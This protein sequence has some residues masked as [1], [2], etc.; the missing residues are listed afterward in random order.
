MCFF[1]IVF[2]T[3]RRFTD[4]LCLVGVGLL[5]VAPLALRAHGTHSQLME[6]V[7]RKIED[8]PDDANLWYQRG[9]L[10]LEHEDAVQ[11]LEDLKKAESLAPGKLPTL[12][13]KGLALE[14][15]GKLTDA[16]SALD[17]HILRFPDHGRGYS[18]RARVL[19]KLGRTEEALADYRTALSKT[20]NAE[21]DL[22]QES[23]AAM[24]ANCHE[25]EAIR[26]LDAGVERLGEIPSLMMKALEIEVK[27]AR[28]DL[29]LTRVEAI[30]KSAP[31]PE[32]WMA[33]RAELL[34]Q[35]QQ[36]EESRAAWQA[37]IAHLQNLPNLERGSNSMS[38]LAERAHQAIAILDQPDRRSIPIPPG[39][40][41]E[42]E[43][44]RAN[45]Q[46][47]AAP[48]DGKLW[49]QRS[50]LLLA[51]GEFQQAL[52]DCD[53]A[54]FLAPSA[55]PTG[56]VRG[57]AWAGEGDLEKGKTVLDDFLTT[58]P[59]HVRGHAARARLLL[60]LKQTDSALEDYQT[61]LQLSNGRP[62]IELVLE[63]VG[64]FE[65]NGLREEAMRT[66][67]TQI[68]ILGENP[69]LLTRALETETAAAQY[70]AAI[71]RVDALAKTS[72]QPEVWMA[73]RAGLLSLAGRGAEARAAWSAILHHIDS[74]PNL[75][76]GQPTMVA[77]AR[78]AETEISSTDTLSPSP[79]SFK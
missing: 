44:Q 55:F 39:A 32:P 79:D 72:P 1:P 53:T 70:D 17:A 62:E 78:Q 13:L 66:L 20:P 25:D 48:S 5:C 24:A 71:S 26:I 6:V 14:L 61:A 60:Q 28:Y 37:L 35:A 9:F 15:S 46:I 34:A 8:S 21:P 74:L 2:P 63:A 52:Q 23:A 42:E 75:Q 40:V 65:A 30:E 58:H 36:K 64:A 59:D 3:I 31:R 27:A 56:Y 11:A 22:I 18:S 43:R 47:T 73:K 16:R 33:K 54:D 19:L 49:Y 45:E 41:H 68:K 7:N 12:L 29:A 51:D 77:L 69:A 10:N 4:T 50:L 67:D 57:Q 38:L 76:R